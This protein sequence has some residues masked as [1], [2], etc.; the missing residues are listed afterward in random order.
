[1]GTF[2][3]AAT[4]DIIMVRQKVKS[5]NVHR[6]NMQRLFESLDSDGIGTVTRKQFHRLSKFPA[7]ST[8]LAS[9]DLQTT[10]FDT[11]FRLIDEDN[12]GEITFEEMMHGIGRLKGPARSIDLLTFLRER[13]VALNIG[14]TD[15]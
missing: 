8:W 15:V 9:M 10:D 13:Q 6:K 1:M 2:K 11:L 4:D 3:V 12:D 7:V 14:S 5:E